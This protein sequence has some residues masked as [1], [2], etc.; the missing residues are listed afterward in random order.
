MGLATVVVLTVE[1]VWKRGST[2]GMWTPEGMQV[3][4][5]KAPWYPSAEEI[6]PGKTGSREPGH[7]SQSEVH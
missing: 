1:S 3:S 7:C 5:G 4:V 2:E 6:L